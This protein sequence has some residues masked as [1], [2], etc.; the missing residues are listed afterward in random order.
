GFV[1]YQVMPSDYVLPANRTSWP[2]D[3]ARNV[4]KALSLSPD[5][6][7]ISLPSNDV[8]LP[9]YVLSETMNNFRLLYQKI[10]AKGVK[11]FIS[12]MQP[13]NDV[14]AAQKLLLRQLVDSIQ[15]NF[16]P[17]SLNFFDDLLTSD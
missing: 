14:S 3:T 8:N 15:N 13:R 1:T 17:N 6:I 2:P 16:G 7:L 4:T 11:A 10:T 5:I 9:D 12:T